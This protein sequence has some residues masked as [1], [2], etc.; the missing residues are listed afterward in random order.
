MDR[1]TSVLVIDDDVDVRDYLTEFL[2]T[3]GFRVTTAA[4]GEAA[5]AALTEGPRRPA[6]VLLDLRMPGLDGFEVLRRYRMND[7]QTPVIALSALGEAETVVRAM[8]LGASDY[9]AKPFDVDQ[10]RDALARVLAVASPIATSVELKPE[11]RGRLAPPDYVSASPAMERI[12]EMVERVAHTDVPI[13][14]RGESGVGKEVVARQLHTRSNRNGRPFIKINCA[15]LPAELLE[16]EL[17]GHERGAFTGATSEKPGKFELANTGTIF[18]DEIGEMHPSLQ[19]KML[20]VLQDEEFYRIGGKRPVRVDARVV[21]ATNRALEEEIARGN[22]RED[23]YYRLNVVSIAVPP[24][25]ERRGDVALLVEHFLKKY[26]DKY[27]GGAFSV[28]PEVMQVFA[29]YAWPGNVREL[30]NMVR[31]LVVLRD[32]SLVLEELAGRRPSSSAISTA[33]SPGSSMAAAPRTSVLAENSEEGSGAAI[34][35]V[36][37]LQPESVSLKAIGRHAAMLAEREAIHRML[38]KTNWNKRKAAVL[39]Q[40][41]YKALLYK[42]KECGIIDPREQASTLASG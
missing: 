37:S 34:G 16:S 19:A 20:Q 26:G 24:L 18:L 17:F 35:S 28:P 40:I 39:L 30:E 7:Q 38:Q 41:S 36:T 31:R 11:R 21:T 8:K 9:L 32:T 23:L 10:L 1:P 5:L 27:K 25:R 4:D 22:F 33:M 42:V 15:A 3:E 14:I 2:T 13:L 6:L 29:S 12:W